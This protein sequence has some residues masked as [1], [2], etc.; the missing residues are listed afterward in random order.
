[1]SRRQSSKR[2]YIGI[3]TWLKI[4]RAIESGASAHAIADK[5]NVA[6]PAV[7]RMRTERRG[8]TAPSQKPEQPDLYVQLLS[9]ISRK[10]LHGSLPAQ[11]KTV[12]FIALCLE[13]FA[14]DAEPQI[15]SCI[16][17]NLTR[18]LDY[19]RRQQSAEWTH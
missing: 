15:Q 4:W 9:E 11:E 2:K 14:K 10:F 16:A 6:Y 19:L 17:A 13:L 5:Y 3:G 8:K 1:M 7:L 18:G 12:P